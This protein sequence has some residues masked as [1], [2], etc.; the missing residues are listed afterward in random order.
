MKS[1]KR[2]IVAIIGVLAII[3][4]LAPSGV[5]AM[6][7][8]KIGVIYPLSGGAA[9]AG[10][11]L[12]AGAELAAEIANSVMPNLP[13]TM[14]KNAGIKS[15]GGAKIKL[16]FKDHEGNPTLGADLAKKLILDDKVDGILGCDQDRKCSLRTVWHSHDQWL[17]H[18]AGADS[19]RVQMVLA[20]HAA[21]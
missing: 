6:K 5:W 12:R 2:T 21:R 7:E 17:I 11:E 15:L 9:A 18:I 4:F 8:I 13:M 14:A 19:T 20:N 16:I 3:G 1:Y 10:R